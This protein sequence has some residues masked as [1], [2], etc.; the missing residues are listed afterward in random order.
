MALKGFSLTF[1]SC[2]IISLPQKQF[3]FDSCLQLESTTSVVSLEMVI[4]DL[5]AQI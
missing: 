3:Q 1:W 4:V 5:S 2:K